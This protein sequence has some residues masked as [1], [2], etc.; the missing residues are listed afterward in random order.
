MTEELRVGFSGAPRAQGFISAF[1]TVKETE[2]VA[3]CDVRKAILEKVGKRFG[4]EK[5]YTDYDEMIRT[6]LDIIVVG[7]PMPLHVPQSV[8]ALKNGKHVMSEVPAAVDL[9][10]C[11]QLVNAVI[12]SGKK[13]MMAENYVYMKPNVLVRELARKGLFGELYFGEGEYI[14][15]LKGLNEITVWRRKWQTGRK[16]VAHI[17]LTAL[18][19]YFNGLKIK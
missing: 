3:L 9:H 13:Y 1:R 18:D 4:I 2:P 12:E 19:R 5:L 17:R 10:Q 15:E 16:M 7:T 8:L 6:D 11:W 14:H